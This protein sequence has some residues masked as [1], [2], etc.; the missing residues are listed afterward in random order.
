MQIIFNFIIKAFIIFVFINSPIRITH[1]FILY[2]LHLPKKN[3]FFNFSVFF[4]FKSVKI[5]LHYYLIYKIY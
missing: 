5:K 1:F 2:I 3:T 4:C